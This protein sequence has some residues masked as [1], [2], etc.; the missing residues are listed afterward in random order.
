MM[1]RHREES[2]VEALKEGISCLTVSSS[3]SN[4]D[5][6]CRDEHV[7]AINNFLVERV[8]YTLQ[9]FGMPGTGK[10]ATVNHALGAF[11]RSHQLQLSAV[12]LNGYIIQ[13]SSDIY[14]TMYQHLSQTRWHTK[15]SCTSEQSVALLEKKLRQSSSKDYPLCVIIIDEADK[16]LEKHSKAMF[17]IID[18]LSLPNV[19]LKLITISNSMDLNMDAKTKSRLDMTQKLV[20]EPYGIQEL[21][22]IL[23]RRISNIYPKLFDDKAV[24]LLCHQ[25]SSQ[26]GDVRRLLQSASAAVCSV[27]LSIYEKESKTNNFDAGIV[28]F[29]ELH[30]V[31]RQTY[32]DRSVEY[33]KYLVSPLIFTILCVVAKEA[34]SISRQGERDIRIPLHLIFVKTT[35]YL[36]AYSNVSRILF[37]EKVENLRQV[38]MIDISIG[39][40]RLPVAGVDSIMEISDEIYVCLLCSYLSIMDSCKLHDLWGEELAKKIFV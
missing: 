25:V 11:S 2:I 9:V 21:K 24:N 6:V 14:Y 36:E 39:D 3:V 29:H 37:V 27:L 31:I 38:G 20:F 15:V 34:E 33:L 5:L 19:N 1:K 12:Y 26:Y 8:H 16:L 18:W 23:L 22:F 40:D 7:K 30:S 4:K 35:H 10:T 17:K 28:T 13:K 32:H